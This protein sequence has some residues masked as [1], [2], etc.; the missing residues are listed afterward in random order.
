MA[1]IRVPY[2]SSLKGQ[3]QIKALTAYDYTFAKL[4]NQAEIDIVLV[5]DSLS[6]I[7]QGKK[8]TINVTMDQMVYHTACVTKACKYSLAVS[9]MPFMSYQ[10]SN[11][12]ALENATRLFQDGGAEAVKLEGGEHIAERIEA[13][14][15]YDLP[16]MG[17]VGL[18]PQSY[19]NL[20]GHK[21]QG[22]N[23]STK[24][25][26]QIIK[27]A[28]AVAN[29]GAFAVVLECIPDDVAQEITASINIPTIGIGS[30]KHCD[31]QIAVTHDVLGF[32][33]AP[34]FITPEEQL[35]EVIVGAVTRYF[36]E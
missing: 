35:S 30:G 32:K 36:K 26:K 25:S 23:N 28:K 33:K 20:G 9:D 17:H 10:I 2:I 31:G 8:N 19:H 34:G 11:E 22:E 16:V 12:Q 14:V 4:L 6:N 21:R 29:A 13:L 3:R 27:D 7:V 1:K 15:K 18:T 5:G 24:N